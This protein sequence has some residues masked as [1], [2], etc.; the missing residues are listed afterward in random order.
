MIYARNYFLSMKPYPSLII[1]FCW[2]CIGA[3]CKQTQYAAG[4]RLTRPGEYL[5]LDTMAANLQKQLED[6]AVKYAFIL[7]HGL[8]SVSRVAGKKRTATDPPEQDLTLNDR[9]NPASVSK[10]IT[11]IA[12]LQLL[13]KKNISIHDPIYLY[14]PKSWNIPASVKKITYADLLS[15]K[16]GIR[17]TLGNTNA[18][19]KTTIQ[20][21]VDTNLIGQYQYNNI[22][23]SICRILVAYLDGY[24]PAVPTMDPDE[25][26]VSDRFRNYLQK[27]IFDQ[28][29]I[30]DVLFKPPMNYSTMFYP[31]PAGSTPG[32]D[33]ADCTTTA[34]P[35]GI[36]LS[37]QELSDL[38]FHLNV[39]TNL[40]SA[41]MKQQMHDYLLG[42]DPVP[43]IGGDS[44][45]AKNG[46]LP[47]P[48]NGKPGVWTTIIQFKNGLQVFLMF[49]GYRWV[50]TPVENAYDSSWRKQ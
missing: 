3:T 33:F 28:V 21:G 16:S 11:A 24:T 18:D 22:N 20:A 31:F 8:Y 49:N 42:W 12:V 39:S 47:L 7:R 41:N 23:F 6:S 48:F 35:L 9:Y 29:P 36:Y 30:K 40:L 32:Y 37:T 25:I 34:G 4:E 46:M 13:E 10:V 44:V 14:L 17:S 26:E 43:P 27:N 38:F 1:V 45:Q 5:L 50:Y 2:L 19:A 15:H